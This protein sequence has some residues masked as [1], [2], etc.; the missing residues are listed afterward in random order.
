MQMIC[1]RCVS[2]KRAIDGV[3]RVC[4]GGQWEALVS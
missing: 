2:T 4:D 1:Q 3:V